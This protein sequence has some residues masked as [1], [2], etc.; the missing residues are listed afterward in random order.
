MHSWPTFAMAPNTCATVGV[1]NRRDR[2]VS[3]P[4]NTVAVVANADDTGL[5]IGPPEHTGVVLMRGVAA[6]APTDPYDP[7]EARMSRGERI[8]GHRLDETLG[9]KASRSDPDYS[10]PRGRLTFSQRTRGDAPIF[11]LS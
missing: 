7:G 3:E 6:Q 2:A 9:L 4:P 11:P 8:G 5:C 1:A 10:V